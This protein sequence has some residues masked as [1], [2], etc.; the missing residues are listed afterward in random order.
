MRNHISN[1]FFWTL[2]VILGAGLIIMLGV[3]KASV[4]NITIFMVGLILTGI[5]GLVLWYMFKIESKE[6]EEELNEQTNIIKS[7]GDKIEVDLTKCEVVSNSWVSEDPKYSDYRIEAYNTIGSDSELNVA[8]S[9]HHVSKI[10]YRTMYKGE[11][12]EFIS[13]PISR[14]IHT[15]KMLLEFQKNTVIY[16]VKDQPDHYMF[17]LDFLVT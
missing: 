4:F 9:S 2:V 7:E 12:R 3:I 17:D 14:D 15:L 13:R 16:I 11:E 5:P 6:V 10:V 1:I 8:H